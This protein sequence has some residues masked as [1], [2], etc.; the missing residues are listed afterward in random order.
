[1]SKCT[2]EAAQ[3]WGF[4]KAANSWMEIR[5]F[6]PNFVCIN[7][8]LLNSAFVGKYAKIYFTFFLNN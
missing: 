2:E 6:H 3:F 1:M 5:H 4:Q 8:Y 7:F